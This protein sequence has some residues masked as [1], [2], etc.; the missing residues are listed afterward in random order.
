M[1]DHNAFVSDRDEI[2][3]LC[4]ALNPERARLALCSALYVYFSGTEGCFF[5]CPNRKV[6]QKTKLVRHIDQIQTAY[7]LL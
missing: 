5:S 6:T 1:N 4:Q 3:S 2:A 7:F